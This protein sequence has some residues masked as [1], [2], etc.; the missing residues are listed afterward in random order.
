MSLGAAE[1]DRR[2]DRLD[3]GAK[4]DRELEAPD[5][6]ERT[7]GDQP[8]GEERGRPDAHLL[9]V[10]VARDEHEDDAGEQHP[11]GL[12]DQAEEDD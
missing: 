9:W 8:D 4:W 10:A 7:E 11:Q 1:A 6:Y 2:L 12:Q 3:R 5:E